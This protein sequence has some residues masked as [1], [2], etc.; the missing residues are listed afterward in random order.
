M[1]WGLILA[2]CGGGAIDRMPSDTLRAYASA[3]EEGR[4]DEAYALLSRDARRQVPI[5]VFR[6]SIAAGRDEALELARAI[7][8]PAVPAAI[9]ASLALPNGDRLDL[10]LEDGQ[11]RVT[12]AA[13]DWYSQVTPRRAAE[14]FLRALEKKRWDVLIRLVPDVERE[15]VPVGSED[16]RAA[17]ALTP[18]KLKEAWEGPQAQEMALVAK[19]L[20]AALPT[21]VIEEQGDVA[22]LAYGPGA[23][24]SFVR[25]NGVWKIRDF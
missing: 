3:I 25:E 19:A 9:T 15:G 23:T 12:A 10:V 6:R 4:T 11:W 1:V 7:E 24:V 8:R 5:E 20:R 14:T 13:V 16:E 17:A 22:S 18:E 21:A 2:G